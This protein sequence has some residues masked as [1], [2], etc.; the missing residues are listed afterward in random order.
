MAIILPFFRDIINFWNLNIFIIREI[1]YVLP[2]FANPC[3]QW[4]SNP[5]YSDTVFFFVKWRILLL[6]IL[7][8]KNANP[9]KLLGVIYLFF[10]ISYAKFANRLYTVLIEHIL[11]YVSE[12]RSLYSIQSLNYLTCQ[13]NQCLINLL[14]NHMTKSWANYCHYH[15][16][17]TKWISIH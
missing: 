2:H 6:K 10:L 16:D 15:Y 4:L 11:E 13:N 12:K 17:M 14:I 7:C 9:N 3:L 8:N 5:Y 1:S